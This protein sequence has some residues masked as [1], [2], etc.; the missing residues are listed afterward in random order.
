MQLT[1]HVCSSRRPSRIAIQIQPVAPPIRIL[2][3][4][5]VLT[6][7]GEPR[8]GEQAA[9][10]M[11]AEGLSGECKQSGSRDEPGRICGL[12]AAHRPTELRRMFV[13]ICVRIYRYG[14][15]KVKADKIIR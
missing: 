9:A 13:I 11:R 10:E 4:I 7:T 15:P 6:P 5:R 8:R 12:A 3:L 2:T 14:G 1:T